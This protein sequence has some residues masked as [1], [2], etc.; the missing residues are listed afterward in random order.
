MRR[1]HHFAHGLRFAMNFPTP[2]PG[3]AL[4]AFVEQ[5]GF[6]TYALHCEAVAINREWLAGQLFKQRRF[7]EAVCML[8]ASE[9]ARHHGLLLAGSLLGEHSEEEN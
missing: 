6:N 8:T 1:E 3:P 5:V 2:P 4:Q 7:D 9:E